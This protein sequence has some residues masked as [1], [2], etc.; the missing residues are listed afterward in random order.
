MH[1][2]KYSR[3]NWVIRERNVD[4]ESSQKNGKPQVRKLMYLFNADLFL[5]VMAGKKKNTQGRKLFIM[6]NNGL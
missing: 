6:P 4:S 3:V 5:V 2:Y 1:N